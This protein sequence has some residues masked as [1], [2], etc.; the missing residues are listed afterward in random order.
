MTKVEILL[1]KYRSTVATDSKKAR[2]FIRQLDYKE[3]FYFLNYIA[4]TY[5]DE[6]I[7]EEAGK[8]KMRKEMN[9]RKWRMAEKYIIEALKLIRIMQKF[10]ILWEELENRIFKMM[11]RFTVLKN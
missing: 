11:L 4:Q 5:L 3:N 1:D 9:F 6:A 2:Y 8:D 10:F 7:F